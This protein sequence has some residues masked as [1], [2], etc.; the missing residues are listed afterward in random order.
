MGTLGTKRLIKTSQWRPFEWHPGHVPYLPRPIY[1][2]AVTRW[3]SHKKQEMLTFHE[4]C[5]YLPGYDVVRVAH[6]FSCLLFF[7]FVC[8]VGGWS[9]FFSWLQ[10]V[11]NMH[12]ATSNSRTLSILCI[13]CKPH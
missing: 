8:G 13:K 1:T 10:I 12:M 6:L 3:V 4:H 2:I 9:V 5:G 7:F 11:V